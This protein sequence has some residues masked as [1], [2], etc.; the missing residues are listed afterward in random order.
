MFQ[1][2]SISKLGVESYF[3]FRTLIN[4]CLELYIIP[5]NLALEN[6]FDY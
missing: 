3:Y 4:N 2:L 5:D 1:F 6:S